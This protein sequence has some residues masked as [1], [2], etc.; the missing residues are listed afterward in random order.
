MY[1]IITS[2]RLIIYRLFT[3]KESVKGVTELV[4]DYLHV[5]ISCCVAVYVCDTC[6]AL[7]TKHVFGTT[8]LP[9][10]N[11]II[12]LCNWNMKRKAMYT[13]QHASTMCAWHK[14]S[15]VKL[16]IHIWIKGYICRRNPSESMIFSCYLCHSSKRQTASRNNNISYYKCGKQ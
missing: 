8:N 2:W 1:T 9:C 13:M 12:S 6:V 16:A 10:I 5:Y 15:W 4:Y 3:Y 11:T 7:F 14:E